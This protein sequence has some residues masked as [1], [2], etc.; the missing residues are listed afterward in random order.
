MI[1]LRLMV[2]GNGVPASGRLD[3]T[4]AGTDCQDQEDY[5]ARMLDGDAH[6]YSK[7]KVY[8]EIRRLS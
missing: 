7:N 5:C 4:E 3:W 8:S 6:K 1:D 2:K